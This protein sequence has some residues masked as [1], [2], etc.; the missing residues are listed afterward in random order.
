MKTI[1][2]KELTAFLGEN[3]SV[4]LPVLM[5]RFDL[6]YSEAVS[7][8]DN[9]I[10]REW[11]S[12]EISGIERSI[13]PD[14]L[15]PKRLQKD[16]IQALSTELDN[17][18]VSAVNYLIRNS[19]GTFEELCRAVRGDDDTREAIRTLKEKKIIYESRGRYYLCIDKQSAEAL[20]RYIRE[21]KRRHFDR[22]DSGTMSDE[23]D[24]LFADILDDD[25][26]PPDDPQ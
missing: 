13:L 18:C 25:D 11:V 5:K 17:D 12:E 20:M 1:S 7:L 8:M 6:R 16:E 15:L 2:L 21:M 19:V 26:D 10:D 9:M 24:R 3:T 14:H 22:E 23:I 4:S